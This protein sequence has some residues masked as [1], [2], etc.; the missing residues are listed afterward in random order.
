MNLQQYKH[1][2]SKTSKDYNFLKIGEVQ[3]LTKSKGLFENKKVCF[4][5]HDIDFCPSSALAI[6]KEE[7]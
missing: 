6:A 5:R 2:I 4:L 3:L 7:N 1:L